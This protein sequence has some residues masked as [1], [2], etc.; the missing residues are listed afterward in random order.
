MNE[1]TVV[2]KKR[3]SPPRGAA[4]TPAGQSRQSGG[5]TAGSGNE[6]YENQDSPV[7]Q[8]EARPVVIIMD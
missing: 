4:A 2:E 3:N 8:I 5:P 7:H 1:Q 6:P